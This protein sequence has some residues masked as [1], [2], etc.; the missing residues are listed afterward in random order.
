MM[1]PSVAA[2]WSRNGISNDKL[3][4]ELAQVTRA[5]TKFLY[6]IAELGNA[7]ACGDNHVV[8]G[9]RDREP[10]PEGN[11]GSILELPA[12]ERAF[13]ENFAAIHR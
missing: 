10:E 3:P 8:V 7:T 5:E 2:E 12:F 4:G 1:P 9:A 13:E 11:E 6:P